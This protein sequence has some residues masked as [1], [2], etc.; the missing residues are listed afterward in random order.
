MWLP[1]GA[2]HA[3]ARVALDGMVEVGEFEGV[4]QEKDGS[5]VSDEVP[6]AGIGVEFHGESANVSFG[7]GCSAFSRNGGKTDE[8]FGLFAYF[9][10]DGCA[11][12]GGDVVC[13]GEGAECS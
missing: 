13:D 1:N 3:G 11:R 6:V 7:V 2:A 12:E 5:V 9:G 10:K 8:A 4:A